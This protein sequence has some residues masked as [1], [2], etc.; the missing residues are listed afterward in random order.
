MKRL[1]VLSILLVS[2]TVFA[3]SIDL[4]DELKLLDAEYQ[5]LS[6][7]EDTRFKEEKAQADAARVALAENEKVYSE[8][9][10]RAQKLATESDTKF[11]KQQYQ[12]LA[13]KYEK[14]LQKL[15]VDMEGQKAV[16]ADFQK[17]ES[18][19]TK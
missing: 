5:N 14:V 8:L 12:E 3:D 1:L 2:T 19:R 10:K 16:I 4:L 7:Q 17:I 9:T 6:T 18:L 15:S 13:K 11:Y